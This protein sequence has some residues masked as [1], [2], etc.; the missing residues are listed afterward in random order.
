MT[1][2]V[3]EAKSAI[4][5]FLAFTLLTGLVYPLLITG[6]A[7]TAWPE[8]AAGSLIVKD[9]RIVGS[10]LIGQN[11]SGSGYFQGRP[12]EVGY[13]AD[14]SGAGN[15]GPTSAK[16]MEQVCRRIEYVRR[17]NN[18]SQKTP[19]PPE[20]VL[21]SAS[22]LDPHISREGALMQ[23]PRIARVRGLPES[24]VKLLVYQHAEPAQFGIMGQERL[25][26]L[27][28]NLAL[29]DLAMRR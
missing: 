9:G 2:I 18:I 5:L 29:D 1:N 15:L 25:N 6:I 22:G 12:S 11:F 21:A 4:L 26:V 13:A 10:E 16:L 14:G 27:M 20:L 17:T 24:E 8:K 23:V 19:V 28:L 7:Q 3:Q